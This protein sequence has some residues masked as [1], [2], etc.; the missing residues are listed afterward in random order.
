MTAPAVVAATSTRISLNQG[1]DP[2]VPHQG[3]FTGCVDDQDFDCSEGE[4]QGDCTGVCPEDVPGDCT[5]NCAGN[6]TGDCTGTCPGDVGG[7]C[8]GTCGTPGDGASDD[9]DDKPTPD[10]DAGDADDDAEVASVQTLPSTGSGASGSD[11]LGW[12]LVVGALFSVAGAG[13]RLR[14]LGL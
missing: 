5:G 9:D 2:V 13:Y 3:E 14:R 11:S 1:D 10:G 12:L 6:V 7:A 8:T 4:V